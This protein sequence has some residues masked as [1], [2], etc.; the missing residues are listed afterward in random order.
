MISRFF[1]ISILLP[2]FLMSFHSTTMEKEQ[3]IAKLK[4]NADHLELE[5]P[6]KQVK[7]DEQT[8]YLSWDI[9]PLEI[10]AYIA[11]FLPPGKTSKESIHKTMQFLCLNKRMMK[12]TAN[13]KC[14]QMLAEKIRDDH[15]K[16]KEVPVSFPIGTGTPKFFKVVRFDDE[17]WP[18]TPDMALITTLINLGSQ[19]AYAH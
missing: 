5:T 13:R 11:T 8:P 18:I 17:K 1:K 3:S 6:A 15:L 12:T 7:I 10:Y 2:I 16:E 19:G 4:R 14:M 9:L